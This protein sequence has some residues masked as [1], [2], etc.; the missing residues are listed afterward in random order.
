MSIKLTKQGLAVDIDETLSW[1]IGYWVEQMQKKFGNPEN[2]SII[3]L[4]KKYRQVQNVPYWQ[5]AEALKWTNEQIH[6]SDLQ[7]ELPLIEGA[8]DYLA[9]IEKIIPIVAYLTVRPECTRAGTQDWLNKHGFPKA[10]LICRPTEMNHDDGSKWKA[11]TLAK[12]YPQVLG[13]IDDNAK[14]LDFLPNDYQGTIFL[15]NHDSHDSN[16]KVISCP[17]WSDVLEAVKRFLNE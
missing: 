9:Q 8:N 15:Y 16:L 1:T 14:L 5:T 4:T 11:E 10:Q 7:T 12:L 3:E 2:L 13:I 17:T 6:S